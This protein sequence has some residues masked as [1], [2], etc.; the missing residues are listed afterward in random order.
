LAE[1]ASESEV[2]RDGRRVDIDI[3]IPEGD[4]GRWIALLFFRFGIH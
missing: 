4:L 2:R 3:A 1:A